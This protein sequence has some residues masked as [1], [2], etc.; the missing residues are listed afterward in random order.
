MRT[1]AASA[2]IGGFTA[3]M[4]V[5]C[6]RPERAEAPATRSVVAADTASGYAY[7]RAECP[8]CDGR[9]GYRGEA[10]EYT[11]EGRNL[12]LCSQ[13]CRA[14][15]EADPAGNL[16]R[17]DAILSD[18]QRPRYPLA[19]SIV[20]GR[21]L[22]AKPIEFI[23]RNRLVRLAREEERRGFLA[24]PD[25][26]MTRLDEAV[27]EA[28]RPTYGM[29]TRCPV[30]GDILSSDTPIDLV[31]ANRMIRVCCPRCAAVV[32]RRPQQYLTLV[33]RANAQARHA[34]P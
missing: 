8:V 3:A 34:G 19:V 33:D 11:H 17:I 21:A 26:F 12:R 7:Y 22:G 30:Q 23:W 29:P 6:A 10:L 14:R 1:S 28:Q 18:D 20:S 16:A 13:E 4:L 31:I 5:A 27:I 2:W 32:R 9:L 15:F 25:R 24:S